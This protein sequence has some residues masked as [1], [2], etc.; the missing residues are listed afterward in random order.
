MR[1]LFLKIFLWF[2]VTLLLVIF[3]VALAITLQP[4]TV[5]ARW[6]TMVA[7]S[8]ALYGSYA[9]QT[10]EQQSPEAA[11]RIF[12]RL[13]THTS[14]NVFLLDGSLN[15]VTGKV[16][17]EERQLAALALSS[18]EPQLLIKPTVAIGA[19][20]VLSQSGKQYV[21]VAELPRP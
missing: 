8:L 6:R 19:Q 1:S 2:W 5:S 7:D 20:L 15:P 11:G 14:V 18:R 17:S 10:A 13:H 21:G 4:E 9:A 12:D 3:A 16:S